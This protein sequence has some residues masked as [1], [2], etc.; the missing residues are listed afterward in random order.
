MLSINILLQDSNLDQLNTSRIKRA[1]HLDLT[2]EQIHSTYK[3]TSETLNQA[4]QFLAFRCG[5]PSLN[6]LKYELMV[7]PMNGLSATIGNI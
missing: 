6:D 1:T 4:M 7:L 2:P 3:K 5:V